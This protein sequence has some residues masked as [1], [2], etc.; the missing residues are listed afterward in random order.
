MCEGSGGETDTPI[1]GIENRVEALKESVSVD[2]V[3]A[4]AAV[5]SEV[6]DDQVNVARCASDGGVERTGPQLG[7]GGQ[8]VDD[9]Y[10]IAPTSLFAVAG[11]SS[12]N[13]R[14]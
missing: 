1:G 7:I 6:G 12:E 5:G 13:L 4:L 11:E 10:D 2:E 3:Q 8:L 14:R 9:L